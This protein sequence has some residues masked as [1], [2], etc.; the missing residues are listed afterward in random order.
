MPVLSQRRT[1][2]P[3]QL[4]LYGFFIRDRDEL[5]SFYGVADIPLLLVQRIKE[6]LVTCFSG[7]SFRQSGP[8]LWSL[9]GSDRSF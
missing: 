7:Y 4:L 5:A 2:S 3:D 1:R 9:F 6:L 8:G